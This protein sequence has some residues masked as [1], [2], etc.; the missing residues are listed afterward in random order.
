MEPE[1]VEIEAIVTTSHPVAAYGGVKLDDAVLDQVARALAAG[2][3]PML[4]SHDVRRPLWSKVH[5]ARVRDRDDGFKEVWARILVERDSWNE[6]ESDRLA[7]GAPGGFSFSATEPIAVLPSSSDRD[8]APLMLAGDAAHWSDDELLNARAVLSGVGEV[9][10]ARRYQFAQTPEAVLVLVIALPELTGLL[11][12]AAYDGLKRLFNEDR[13]TVL[14]LHVKDGDQEVVARLE[15]DEPDV[16]DDAIEFLGEALSDGP[17]ILAW[18]GEHWR[19]I[20]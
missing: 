7:A 4:N 20:E 1:T 8:D 13:R 2:E 12:N 15:T 19:R 14:H 10:V 17:T 5:E 18:D 6:Y 3:L 11:S 9:S 16:L